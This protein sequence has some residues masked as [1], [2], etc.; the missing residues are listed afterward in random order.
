MKPR[1]EIMATVIEESVPPLGAGDKLT[2]AEFLRRW[3]AHPEIKNAELIGGIVY[4]ASPVSIEHG[5]MDSD[6]GGW[7][8][9]YKVATPGTA[10]GHNT[11]TF[12]LEDTPQPDLNLRILPEYGGRSFVRNKYLEGIPELLAEICRSSTAYDM[13][14]KLD[15]YQAAQVP[16]YLAI[17]LFERE[18]RWH[19]L[20][21]GKYKMLAPD[22]DGLLRSRVFPGQ[23]L[24]GNALLA[25]NTHQVLARLQEGLQSPEHERFVTELASKKAAS[26]K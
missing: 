25:G 13:H 23:W 18:V 21:D 20:V 7:L 6:V 4:M 26:R 22:A 24:D 3:E 5:D 19:I 10:S 8:Y 9:T 17:L 1:G 11:T 12:L 14:I 2:R 15:L 16:E